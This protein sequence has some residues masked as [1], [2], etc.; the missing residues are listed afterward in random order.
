MD[1]G[2]SSDWLVG[3]TETS[4]KPPER[5]ILGGAHVTLIGEEIIF[6]Y[7]DLVAP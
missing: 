7:S 5:M 4:Y 1:L 3:L 6:V 2:S